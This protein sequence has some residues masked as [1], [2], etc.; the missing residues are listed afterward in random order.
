M[1]N[2]G[3]LVFGFFILSAL[4]AYR[5]GRTGSSFSL[6][7]CKYIHKKYNRKV[8]YTKYDKNEENEYIE[9]YTQE[10]QGFH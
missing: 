9:K 8:K 10:N 5:I 3:F 7:T 6:I 1:V 4:I 2:E